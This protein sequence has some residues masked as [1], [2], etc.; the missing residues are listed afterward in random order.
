NTA[1]GLALDMALPFF[2]YL[3]KT[4]SDRR[5]KWFFGLA[6]VVGIPAIF[7]TYSR[8]ALIGLIAM[9]LFMLLQSRQKALLI[10][11]V[12]ICVLFAVFFTPQAWRDRMSG[13]SPDSLDNSALSRI[14]AWTYSWNVATAYPVMGG[15]FEAFTPALFAQY[16]PN[17]RD[18]HGPHSIY[19]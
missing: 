17:P 1:F 13:T 6:F 7:F 14:N 2:F 3:A 18:V 9:G 5:I 15:G 10:P 4:E 16:A 11:M 19:F 8:G 12:V